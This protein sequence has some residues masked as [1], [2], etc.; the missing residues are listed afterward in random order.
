[1]IILV[2]RCAMAKELNRSV[3]IARPLFLRSPV[4]FGY[5]CEGWLRHEASS[6]K[7]IDSAAGELA[8]WL[9]AAAWEFSQKG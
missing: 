4:L 9:K 5:D 1:V 2:N 3:S 8:E 6:H 7:L